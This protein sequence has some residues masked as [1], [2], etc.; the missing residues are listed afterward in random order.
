MCSEPGSIYVGAT[1]K[2]DREARVE[3][4][5]ESGFLGTFYYAEIENMREAEDA[6]LKEKKFRWNTQTQSNRKEEPG[7]VYL[8]VGERHA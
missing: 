5:K 7:I 6:L 1:R 4:F 3:A 8:I 2:E